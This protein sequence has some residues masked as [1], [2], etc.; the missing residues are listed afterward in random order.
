MRGGGIVVGVLNAEITA[1]FSL[2][3]TVP[4]LARMLVSMFALNARA[5]IPSRNATSAGSVMRR[6]GRQSSAPCD[7]GWKAARISRC[8]SDAG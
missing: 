1:P 4:V 5:M 6:H 8:A 7:R 2:I 3:V